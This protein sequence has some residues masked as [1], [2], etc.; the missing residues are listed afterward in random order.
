[1]FKKIAVAF[2]ESPEAEHAFRSA[3]DLARLVSGELYLITVIENQPAYMS[4]VSAVA[5]EVPLLLKNQKQAFYEDL[6]NKARAAAEQTGINLHSE[7]IEGNEIDALLEGIGRLRPELLV[8]GLR[9]DPGGVSRYLGGT[10][11]QLA[12]HAKCDVLGVR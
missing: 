12:L 8:V 9:R 2:D 7:L 5:P 10:A 11:H 3:L 4:Y 1:M 6:H